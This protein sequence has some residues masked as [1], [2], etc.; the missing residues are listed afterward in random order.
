MK[1]RYFLAMAIIAGIISCNR[2]E[3]IEYNKDGSIKKKTVYTSS[4]KSTYR[5]IDYFDGEH[6][7]GLHE[8]ADGIQHG[9]SFN[10]YPNGNI[11]SVF[12]YNMGHL[13]SVA[14]YY[15]QQGKLTDKGLFINDSLVVKEEYFYKDNL[16]KIN[17]FSKLKDFNESGSLLYNNLGLL[18]LDNSYYYI[19]S[20]VD[21]IPSGDSIKVDVNF[22]AHDE[23]ASGMVLTLG[24]LN[25]N[26]Q[27]PVKE[28]T[29]MSDSMSL[30]FYYK[31]RNKGYNLILGKL[32]YI[33]YGSRDQVDEFVFYHDFLAY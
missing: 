6:I 33:K 25:E 24:P 7:A 19:A 18:G 30:S 11:K 13:T 12:Y 27:F 17:V 31:P 26:L 32:M 22:I 5:E 20:S 21:S 3:K 8:F 15:N 14:R 10:Y 1:F 4:D 28:K 23:K 9:R 16:L 29:Y 2:S